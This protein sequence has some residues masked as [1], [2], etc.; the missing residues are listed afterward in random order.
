MHNKKPPVLGGFFN[1]KG[2]FDEMF[3]I[4]KHFCAFCLQN[5]LKLCNMYK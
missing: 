3:K 5:S 1:K 4:F 2:F